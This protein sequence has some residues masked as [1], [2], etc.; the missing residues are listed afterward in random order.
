MKAG[1]RLPTCLLVGRGPPRNLA[2]AVVRARLGANP[3]E[4][5]KEGPTLPVGLRNLGQTCSVNSALQCLFANTALRRGLFA[6]PAP[7]RAS[8]PV[9]H[10]RALLA[11]LQGGPRAVVDPTAFAECLQLDS[12]VQQDGSEFLKLLLQLL[13]AEMEGSPQAGLVCK[14]DSGSSPHAAPFYELELGV[15]GSAGLADSLQAA[16]GGMLVGDNQYH[17]DSCDAKVRTG[18]ARATHPSGELMKLRKLPPYLCFSLMR[19]VFDMKTFSKVKAHDKFRF[20]LQLDLGGFVDSAAANEEGL[21]S[22]LSLDFATTWVGDS[23]RLNQRKKGARHKGA[24][25]GDMQAAAL[26]KVEMAEKKAAKE[27]AATSV[28]ISVQIDMA[29]AL[30]EVGGGAVVVAAEAVVRGHTRDVLS[31]AWS[32]DGSRLATCS[33]DGTARVWEAAAGGGG[34]WRCVATLEGHTESVRSVAWSPD[35]RRLATGSIDNTARVWEAAPGGRGGWR[36]VA[37]LQG[38]INC[39]YSVAWSPDGTRLATGSVDKTARV[40]EAAPGGGGGWRCVASLEGHTHWVLSV[41]WSP[42]GRRLATASQDKTAR[43][44]EAAPGGGGGWRCVATLEGHTECVGSVAWSPDGRQL[45]TGSAG[46]TARVW[47]AAPG[48]GGGWRCAAKLE[49]HT[50][51]VFFVAW[52]PDGRRIATAS[53]DETARVWEAAPGG[54]G[55][56]RCVATLEEH[57][58]WV[59]SVAWSP[60]GS[61]LATCIN[62]TARVWEAAPGGGGGWRCVATLEGHTHWVLSVAW[63][64]DGRRLATCSDDKTARVWRPP[65]PVRRVAPPQPAARQAANLRHITPTQLDA[66]LGGARQA[67][68]SG[69]FG[70]V[71]RGTLDGAPVAIKLLDPGGLQGREEYLAEAQTLARLR[72]RHIVNIYAAC[73]ERLAVVMEL[74]EGGTLEERL[75]EGDAAWNVRMRMLYEACVGLLF[76]HNS[77][78]SAI[79][80]RDFKPSNILLS[81]SGMA[82]LA[83][84]GLAKAVPV[85][86]TR[87][88]SHSTVVGS[89]GFIDPHYIQSAEYRAAS[90]V[91]SVGVSILLALLGRTE[92]TGMVDEVKDAKDDGVEM[93]LLDRRP[94]AGQWDRAKAASVMRLALQCVHSNQSRRPSLADVV[95]QLAE[96]KDARPAAGPT[97]LDMEEWLICP[98]TQDIMADPVLAEDGYTYEREAIAAHFR[99][100]AVSPMT[101]LPIGTA[102]FPNRIVKS[103]VE[104]WLSRNRG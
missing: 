54:G 99:R 23:A 61:R 11:E 87:I 64:P 104:E 95:E 1:Q 100:R 69:G 53:W 39:V 3:P 44:W 57:T 96:F 62:N 38:H 2:Q 40:W 17:C 93:D 78:P 97:A 15:K 26:L 19:F 58:G 16:V 74:M 90:D 63:S 42:D 51:N 41:A 75:R 91:Y 5:R 52:S 47:E 59:F 4:Q 50:E 45:A 12:R 43:V 88:S 80:H 34:G 49:G 84:V 102:V 29:A 81:G 27:R 103:M 94:G 101:N 28:T 30:G 48:E 32:P 65:A 18:T 36:C 9:A 35:G 46:K 60:D 70:T 82:K 66:A 92:P 98:I 22:D 25:Q 72:H 55:G 85:G 73:E 67:L 79:L 86:G 33:D 6:L 13:E 89:L 31:V 37:T 20:P 76:L 83:D 8:T 21:G 24:M 68:G 71:Y 7:W 56:W 77:S 14:K 10:L